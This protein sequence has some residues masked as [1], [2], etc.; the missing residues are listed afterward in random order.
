VI[1]RFFA[2]AVSQER[3]MRSITGMSIRQFLDLVI[4]M[5]QAHLSKPQKVRQRMVGG[6]RKHSLKEWE[7]KTFFILFYLKVYPTYDFASILCLVDKS[8]ICRWVKELLPILEKALGYSLSLPK[9][10][11]S[12]MQEFQEAFPD[13][14]DIIVDV[15]ER[16]A[17]RPGSSKALKR[18]YSG[19]KKSHTRKNTII[20]DEY[21]RIRF[22]SRTKEG[23][24]HDLK[25]LKKESLISYIPPGTSI[26]ADKG[27]TGLQSQVPPKV[28]LHIPKK[29]RKKKPL[30]EDEL[31]ENCA[32]NSIRMSVE[33]AIGGM[34]RFASM[35]VP[36]RNKDWNIEN[37]LP[38]LCAGLWNFHLDRN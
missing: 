28:I 23:R 5:H 4:F 2:K 31:A 12:S 18:R 17:R 25:L 8:Q 38:A 26:W 15:T 34:K 29:R 10:K 21:K 35:Q 9:R 32:I 6:G 16:R 14:S 33:H 37:Q 11:I 1:K 20:I 24:I 30:T 7:E 27:Y 36:I 3:S 22:I 13:I 19:K